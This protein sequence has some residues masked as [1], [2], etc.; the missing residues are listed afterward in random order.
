MSHHLAVLAYGSLLADP[1]DEL[2]PVIVDRQ[3]VQT[4]FAVEYARCSSTRGSAPTLV[5]VKEPGIGA[6]VQ[7]QLL[8]LRDDVTVEAARDILYRRETHHVG[9]LNRKYDEI[10]AQLTPDAV[11]IEQLDDFA[12]V[13]VV[14]YAN[15]LAN[16]DFILDAALPPEDK[17][18]R[19]AQRAVCSVT[20]NTFEAGTDG[21]R[22]LADAICHGI[23][24]SLTEA[25]RAAVLRCAD[26]A[27]D[28]EAAR[29]RIARKKDLV[30][31]EHV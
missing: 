21:I 30:P 20:R 28:L 26:D 4:P 6:P 10:K 13:Q 23:H 18:K 11:R 12:G 5:K 7:A 15:L 1:G 16:L 19:L 2:V 25:Y 29:Q 31:E 3:P 17:A 24:T 14:L 8:L 9:E 22:Y 27:P